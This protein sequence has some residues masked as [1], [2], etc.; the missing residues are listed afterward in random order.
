MVRVGK[1][2]WEGGE[3]RNGVRNSSSLRG[4][5][6]THVEEG[7]AK[8]AGAAEISDQVSPPPRGVCVEFRAGAESAKRGAERD[9]G[10]NAHVQ[11]R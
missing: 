3:T 5:G 4:W 7:R 9:E 1:M 6:T 8:K 2:N 10:A 11:D